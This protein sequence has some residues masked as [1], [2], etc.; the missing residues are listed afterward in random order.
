M[1]RAVQIVSIALWAIAADQDARAGGPQF[2]YWVDVRQVVLATAEGKNVAAEL[3]AERRHTDEELSRLEQAL[4]AEQRIARKNPTRKAIVLY[5]EKSSA[6]EDALAAA[7][8]RLM[9]FES[10]RIHPLA[11]DVR[12]VINAL[13]AA[14]TAQRLLE[15]DRYAPINVA[16]E[17]DA[18]AWLL[19]RLEKPGKKPLAKK[20]ACATKF[21]MY[22]DLERLKTEMKANAAALG[23]LE[24][25]R[26]ERLGEISPVSSAT[27]TPSSRF[28]RFLRYTELEKER[29]ARERA[30]EASMSAAAA[31]FITETALPMKQVIFL[32]AGAEHTMRLSPS[33]EV[34]GWLILLEH[35][36]AAI[37]DVALDCP[38][39]WLNRSGKKVRIA[40]GCGS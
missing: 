17:C 12:A 11:E 25:L 3:E 35:G 6:L 38:C 28:E 13:N 33:C 7:E 18:T 29:R 27:V 16:P 14:N 9:A 40:R 39:V 8:L 15:I 21:F 34:T 22:V 26:E 19:S 37:E 4:A 24:A 2:F 10:A 30:H 31:A 1:R 23:A 36:R 20:S 5:E 32:G